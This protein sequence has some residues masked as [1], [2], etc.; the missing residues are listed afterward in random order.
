VFTDLR[1]PLTGG[2]TVPLVFT[3]ANAGSIAVQAPVQP[4]AYEYATFSPP[5][6]QPTATAKPG[7]S[8][9]PSPGATASQGGNQPT[10]TPSPSGTP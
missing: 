6:A 5:A 8:R 7:V 1:K 10:S 3:F 9:S 2:Q 4:R